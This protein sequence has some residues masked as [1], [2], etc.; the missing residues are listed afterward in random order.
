VTALQLP[1]LEQPAGWQV[2]HRSDPAAR[3]LAD[4]HYSRGR[5]G[6]SWVGPPG[7]VLVLVTG[8]KT[9]LWVTHWPRADLAQDGLDA[10]RCS[11]FRN[12]GPG[13]SSALITLAMATTLGWWAVAR[14][15]WPWWTVLPADGWVTW[16]DPRRVASPNPG[17]C[18]QRAGWTRDRSWTHRH[19]T[20]LRAQVTGR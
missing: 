18:F 4:R 7:R 15:G 19:L 13:R 1:G 6:A 17:Y 8:D 9:A 3:A 20:R 5:P 2:R 10:R 12:E 14:P 16:V 11:L